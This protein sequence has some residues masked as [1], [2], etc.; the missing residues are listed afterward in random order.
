ME[1]SG[2]STSSLRHA[3]R[4]S[5]NVISAGQLL[6]FAVV[7]FAGAGVYFSV[8]AWLCRVW[9]WPVMHAA[10]AAFLVVVIL[11]YL[12][13]YFWTFH[14]RRPH[15]VAVPRFLFMI[16]SGLAINAAV[17]QSAAVLL[18]LS[19]FWALVLGVCAVVGWNLIVSSVWV[20]QGRG[21]VR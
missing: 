20:F 21:S 6:R 5:S 10:N 1:C 8:T 17:L 15:S 18:H 11:N 7:G 16:V 12:L 9:H 14:T 3:E 4:Q 2:S 13:H 19:P